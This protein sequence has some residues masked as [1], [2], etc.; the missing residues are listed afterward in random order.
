MISFYQQVPLKVE[1]FT[2]S[3]ICVRIS[4]WIAF[5]LCL[6]LFGIGDRKKFVSKPFYHQ[7]C[8]ES[9]YQNQTKLICSSIGMFQPEMKDVKLEI[10]ISIS[11]E[12][13]YKLNKS[14]LSSEFQISTINVQLTLYSNQSL[15]NSTEMKNYQSYETTMIDEQINTKLDC[16][17]WFDHFNCIGEL[18]EINTN[19]NTLF[20]SHIS[21]I[22]PPE[23][24]TLKM[25]YL[26][27]TFE[28]TQF[29]RILLSCQFLFT[30]IIIYAMCYL[31]INIDGYQKIQWPDIL[32]W[33][34]FLLVL[35][36]FYNMPIQLFRYSHLYFVQGYTNMIQLFVQTSLLYFWLII[37]EFQKFQNM[38]ME[39]IINK[40]RLLQLKHAFQIIIVL[41]YTL[42][43]AF[44][45]LYLFYQKENNSQFDIK[46]DIQY[47]EIYERYILT[48]LTI[49]SLCFFYLLYKQFNYTQ[50]NMNNEIVKVQET[51]YEIF[52][53]QDQSKFAKV[54]IRKYKLLHIL[55]TL[56][57]F[58]LLYNQYIRILRPKQ[59]TVLSSVNEWSLINIYICMIIQFYIPSKRESYNIPNEVTD[60]KIQQVDQEEAI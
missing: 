47:Y 58:V 24:Q 30:V 60:N 10:N 35:M 39:D 7:E 20:L 37:F 49:Y 17:K 50:P 8:Q 15:D 12:D 14:K 57:F 25:Q 16:L 2:H 56:C 40:K 3:Q 41:L 18:R 31:Y 28:N 11:N 1:A 19:Q 55:S 6:Q 5:F 4:C 27:S 48:I 52:P 9:D 43:Q 33:I 45:N 54:Q 29:Y 23:Y 21:I 36:V 44:M 38:T 42:P 34:P 51:Q 46:K 26:Q 22:K 59:I 32:K 13:L 53:E